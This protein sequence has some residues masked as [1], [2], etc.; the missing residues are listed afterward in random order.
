M[1]PKELAEYG[2]FI[3]EPS[4][5]LLTSSA[6]TNCLHIPRSGSLGTLPPGQVPPPA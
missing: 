3:L 4:P 5:V 1:D 6:S 2:R